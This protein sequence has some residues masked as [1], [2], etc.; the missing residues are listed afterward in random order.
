[1]HF[2]ADEISNWYRIRACVDPAAGVLLTTSA[3]HSVSA[4]G[5]LKLLF[6]GQNLARN[7]QPVLGKYRL[8]RR[9][10]RAF[11]PQH[12]IPP[13]LLFRL[14]L[15]PLVVNA[16][17][18]DESHAAVHDQ[19]FPVGSV[20]HLLQQAQLRRVIPAHLASRGRQLFEVR[21]EHR[22][23]ADVIQRQLHLHARPRPFGKRVHVPLRDLA[24]VENVRFQVDRFPGSRNRRQLR[25]VE[26][27]A[28]GQH[29]HLVPRQQLRLRQYPQQRTKVV[30]INR[31]IGRLFDPVRQV[32]TEQGDK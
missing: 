15:C 16:G 7:P 30:G 17:A 11:H 23:A 24:F 26:A 10:R 20:V 27:G 5:K 18:S 14:I 2:R 8:Q 22:K 9:Y 3:I 6:A 31:E 29:F 4:V 1:M 13:A 28:V 19:Q 12:R 25:F 32:R 21:L